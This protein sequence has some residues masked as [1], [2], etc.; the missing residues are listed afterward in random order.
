[1]HTC[2]CVLVAAFERRAAL[3]SKV[4]G[5]LFHSALHLIHKGAETEIL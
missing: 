4:P 2:V 5:L 1:M 3:E